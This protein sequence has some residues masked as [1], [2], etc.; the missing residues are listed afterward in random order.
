MDSALLN[1]GALSHKAQG[2]ELRGQGDEV[3][4]HGFETREFGFR[5]SGTR[6]WS[7]AEDNRSSKS[8]PY[9]PLTCKGARSARTREPTWVNRKFVSS[10]LLSS[11]RWE[12][13]RG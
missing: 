7:T 3:S 10:R 6:R 8:E 1:L 5:V 9:E 4:F 2:L 13:R 11:L 12:F